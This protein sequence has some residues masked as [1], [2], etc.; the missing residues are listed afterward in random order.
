MSGYTTKKS[1]GC[2]IQVL[3]LLLIWI[4]RTMNRW[5]GGWVSEQ[6]IHRNVSLRERFDT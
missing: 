3:E 4:N 6:I 2:L 1:I 5:D